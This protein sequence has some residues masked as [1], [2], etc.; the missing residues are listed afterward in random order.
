M[1]TL[2]LVSE[3][4]SLC[5]SRFLDNLQEAIKGE[6]GESGID[7]SEDKRNSAHGG[8]QQDTEVGLVSVS[9]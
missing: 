6:L 9:D 1:A 3:I 5:L 8:V 4:A 7:G 2:N